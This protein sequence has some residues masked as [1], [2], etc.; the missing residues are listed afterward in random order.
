MCIFPRLPLTVFNRTGV[1]GHHSLARDHL[2]NF[3][4]ATDPAKARE[5]QCPRTPRPHRFPC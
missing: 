1:V 4:L 2:A 5:L 3:D